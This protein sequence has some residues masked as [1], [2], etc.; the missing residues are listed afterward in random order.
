LETCDV[1]DA[2]YVLYSQQVLAGS[3]RPNLCSRIYSHFRH[4]VNH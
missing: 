3:K 4:T 1:C 2:A